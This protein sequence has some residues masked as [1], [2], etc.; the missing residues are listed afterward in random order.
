MHLN[1][2]AQ[3]NDPVTEYLMVFRLGEQYLIRAEARIQLGKSE[4]ASDLNAIRVRAGLDVY[5]GSTDKA[6]LLNAIQHERQVE[7]FTELGHRWFDMKRTG[8]LDAIM[9]APG[10]ACSAKG[11]A[12]QS[13]KQLFPMPFADITQDQNLKQNTGY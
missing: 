12:W 5:A 6:S 2:K 8:N 11:G 1:T 13:Y 7:L 4:G 9:G 3:K 10:N